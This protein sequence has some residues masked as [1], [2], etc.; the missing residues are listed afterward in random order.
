M[1]NCIAVLVHSIRGVL[2]CPLAFDLL[3]LP[4]RASWRDLRPVWQPCNK[5]PSGLYLKPVLKAALN[6]DAWTREAGEMKVLAHTVIT[7]LSVSACAGCC[8]HIP[9]IAGQTAVTPAL[10]PLNLHR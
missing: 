7:S 8:A 3:T 2:F 9:L 5:Y 10:I 4:I 1:K 6:M